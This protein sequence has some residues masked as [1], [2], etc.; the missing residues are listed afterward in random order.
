MPESH[1]CT[2]QILLPVSI[3]QLLGA[4]AAAGSPRP[5]LRLP[6]AL[7]SPRSPGTG[8]P[9]HTPTPPQ[10]APAHRQGRLAPAQTSRHFADFPRAAPGHARWES[11]HLSSLQSSPLFATEPQT[12]RSPS[13]PRRAAF[14]EPGPRCQVRFAAGPRH[15]AGAR[16]ELSCRPGGHS[17]PGTGH[18]ETRTHQS[19]LGIAEAEQQRRQLRAPPLHRDARSSA[20]RLLASCTCRYVPA[21]PSPEL[22]QANP[23]LRCQGYQSPS[24]SDAPPLQCLLMLSSFKSLRHIHGCH[25]N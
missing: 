25:R 17:Q 5:R 15:E 2:C 6:A 4:S 14:A 23:W 11:E 13:P 21:L 12:P 24:S 10:P 16:R 7:P 22:G 9:T 19:F 8:A 18:G 3:S 20:A 1:A